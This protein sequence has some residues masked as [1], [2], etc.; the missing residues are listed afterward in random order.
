[1]FSRFAAIHDVSLATVQPHYKPS[2]DDTQK[3]LQRSSRY[4][5]ELP[6]LFF[7]LLY[8]TPSLIVSFPLSNALPQSSASS[9]TISSAGMI[10]LTSPA[11][12]PAQTAARE[13]SPATTACL[14]RSRKEVRTEGSERSR[15][16]R[17]DEVR[18]EMPRAS[19]SSARRPNEEEEGGSRRR[20]WI[21]YLVLNA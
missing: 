16:G 13:R 10:S 15:E 3:L 5:A 19:N 17:V 21:S 6:L 12:V 9:F 20:V 4:S 8:H 2:K 7:S 1:V 18:L 11:P 14:Y